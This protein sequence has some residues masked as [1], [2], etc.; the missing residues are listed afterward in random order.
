MVRP[1]GKR[2]AGVEPSPS[3]RFARTPFLPTRAVYGPP[4][5]SQQPSSARTQVLAAA[6]V[7]LVVPARTVI[8]CREVASAGVGRSFARF[9]G[10]GAPA[11][12]ASWSARSIKARY[13]R[14]GAA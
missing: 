14:L 2:P 8:S 10:H 1:I 5:G 4:T 7:D 3:R 12:V 9:A 13:R 11:M 6:Y